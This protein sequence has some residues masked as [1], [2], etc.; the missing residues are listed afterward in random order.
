MQIIITTFQNLENRLDPIFYSADTQKF[1]RGNL[2]G[3]EKLENISIYIKNGFSAGKSQQ[4]NRKK[5]IIQLRPT[6][7]NDDGK[8]Y[9]DKN[10]YL[11]EQIYNKKKSELLVKGEVLFN[12]TNSQDIV[13]KTALF[14]INGE[15]FCSNHITR[16]FVNKKKILPE[17]LWIVLNSYQRQNIF[18][19]ICTNWN[20]QS[21]INN[22]VLKDLRIPVPD[23]NKQHQIVDIFSSAFLNK[24]QKYEEAK[25]IINSIEEYTLRELR[26][27]FVKPK[28]SNTFTVQ[29][30]DILGKRIDPKKYC[31]IPNSILEAIRSSKYPKIQLSKLITDNFSGDWGYDLVSEKNS[32]K[33]YT[34]VNILRNTNFDNDFNIN[35]NEVARRLISKDKFLL[36]R[37]KVDD[38]LIE[39]SGGSPTQPVGRI[40]IIHEISGDYVFSNFLQCIRINKSK[41]LPYFLYAYLRAIY[42]LDYMEYIQNQTT[43]IK[44]LIWDEFEEIPIVIPPKDI[45]EKIAFETLSKIKKAKSLMLEADSQLRK[46]KL[47]IDKQLLGEM[48]DF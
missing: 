29:Y 10:I 3:F 38:I 27:N 12:N 4:D 48:I 23:L 44:N 25:F 37:L 42:S 1:L 24:Q 6:N 19:K 18:Y 41:C 2:L 22:Q 47:K 35:F 9:F 15:Y 14:D 13:G 26:I 43:G 5:K 30:K 21:G 28:L 32:S 16:I 39:K 20:N 40:A 17:F 11:K 8:L 34:Q 45:Q 36:K 31:G 33:N 7:I 46:I